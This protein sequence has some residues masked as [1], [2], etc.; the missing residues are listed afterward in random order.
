MNP[1]SR[2]GEFFLVQGFIDA[3]QASRGC[4]QLDKINV[5]FS[6]DEY[7]LIDRWSGEIYRRETD[8]TEAWRAVVKYL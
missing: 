8:P 7:I 3:M 4:L 1:M 2:M 6:Q 5:R